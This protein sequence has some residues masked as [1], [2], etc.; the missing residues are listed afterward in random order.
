MACLLESRPWIISHKERPL[1]EGF[2]GPRAIRRRSQA[3]LRG[4]SFGLPLLDQDRLLTV[5]P[6]ARACHGVASNNRINSDLSL[7][8]QQSHTY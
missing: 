8:P 3:D 1:A 2:I 7:I 4:T 5:A 6:G